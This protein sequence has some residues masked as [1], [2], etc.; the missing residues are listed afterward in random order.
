MINLW[1]KH[2]AARRINQWWVTGV[3]VSAR[4]F[5]LRGTIPRASE[6]F[7]QHVQER[8]I[9]PFLGPHQIFFAT[10]M[11]KTCVFTLLGPWLLVRRLLVF[12]EACWESK[13]P[14]PQ[15]EDRD[16]AVK[17]KHFAFL[18]SLTLKQPIAGWGQGELCPGCAVAQAKER[19]RKVLLTLLCAW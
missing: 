9:W 1:D 4:A 3:R 6:T 14:R 13:K 15:G 19:S 18:S 7:P 10:P 11:F 16:V 17:V 2:M 5:G 8:D 12:E